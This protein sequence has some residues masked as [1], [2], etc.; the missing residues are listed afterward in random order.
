[1]VEDDSTRIKHIF[2]ACKEILEFT[3]NS[4]KIQFENSKI[5]TYASVHLIEIIGEAASSVTSELKQK[6]SIIPWKNIIGMRNRLIHGYFDID[7]DIVWQTI[8]KDIPILL[9]E[10]KNIINQ[11]EIE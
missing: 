8:K 6:Y 7:P 2:D 3:N 1:M 4:S 5:L 11:E 10:I 9:V